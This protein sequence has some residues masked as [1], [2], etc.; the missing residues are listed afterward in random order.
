[1]AE[2]GTPFYLIKKEWSGTGLIPKGDIDTILKN[3]DQISEAVNQ[4]NDA[5]DAIRSVL[6][7]PDDVPEDGTLDDVLQKIGNLFVGK[8]IQVTGTG[9]NLQAYPTI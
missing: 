6:P 7:D 9:I 2:H 5:I 3:L 1:M 8:V 4:V